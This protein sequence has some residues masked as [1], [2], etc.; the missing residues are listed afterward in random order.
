MHSPANFFDILM[1]A[2]FNFLAR[3]DR[4]VHPSS[5]SIRDPA[6]NSTINRLANVSSSD[7]HLPLLG[8]ELSKYF[9]IVLLFFSI[10]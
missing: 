5:Q 1:G 9:G 8:I 6:S 4:K 2:Q 10:D 3:Y 7:D